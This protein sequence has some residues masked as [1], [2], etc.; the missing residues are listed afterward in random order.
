[1]RS[2]A[3]TVLIRD[4]AIAAASACVVPLVMVALYSIA[5]SRYAPSIAFSGLS[6]SSIPGWAIAQP[7]SAPAPNPPFDLARQAGVSGLTLVATSLAASGALVVVSFGLVLAAAVPLGFWVGIRAP[8]S[9]GALV[10]AISSMG[11]TLPA[12]FVA[13]LL[14]IAAIFLTEHVHRTVVPVYGYG[15]DGHLVIPVIAL[16]LAPFAYLTRLVALAAADAVRSD[17]V[18]TARAKGLSERSVAYRHIA[19]NIAGAVGE[20]A[21]GA[22]RLMLGS[23][24]IVEYLLAWPGLGLLTLRAANVQDAPIFLGSALLFAGFFLAIEI[25]LDLLTH[26]RGLVSG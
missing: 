2:A 22:L 19:A 15:L 20:S 4:A 24:V 13:L 14:Q 21:L 7:G 25:G 11:M 5:V 9:L 18:R 16:A 23:L 12:F 17:Y 26:R 8:R 3:T 10:L 6:P 1:M